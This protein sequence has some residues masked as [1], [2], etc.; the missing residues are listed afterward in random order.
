VDRF[1]NR[2]YA[3]ETKRV[4]R[5]ASGELVEGRPGM[6]SSRAEPVH[7]KLGFSPARVRTKITLAREDFHSGLQRFLRFFVTKAQSLALLT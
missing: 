2:Q 1:S 6:T 4:T 5:L 3:P 7:K